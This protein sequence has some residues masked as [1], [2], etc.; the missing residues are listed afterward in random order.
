VPTRKALVVGAGIGGLAAAVALRRAGWEVR[1]FERATSPRELGFALLLAPNAMYALGELGLADTIRRGGFIATSGEMRRPDGSVL[2]RFDTASLRPLLEEDAVCILRP[3]LHGALLETVGLS[4]I[5]LEAPAIRFDLRP[6]GVQVRLADGRTDD[7]Q[8]LVG[9]D[10]VASVIR[11]QLHPDEPP[12]RSSGLLAVRGVARDAVP[13]LEGSS[14]AQYFGRGFEAGVARAGEREVYWYLSI[15][16]RHFPESRDV[17]AIAERCAAGFHEPFRAI[18]RETAPEDLRLDELFE[19]DP[20]SPWGHGVVTLLGDAAHPMLPHAGQGAAQ[21]LEDAVVLGSAL[22]DAHD[23]PN[24][25]SALRRYEQLRIPRT[26]AVVALA[27]R[28]SRMGSI[29]NPFGCWV[30][31][32]IIRFIP[33]TV[34]L[35]SLVALGKP[36]R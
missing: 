22:R 27:R 15:Q 10:G 32:Q 5:E 31:D 9:A 11:R 35:K 25:G 6:D 30:R 34:I 4:S 16:A 13:H 7:G 36:P 12:P 24:I 2:R 29:D 21:A 19:R 23:A 3:V 33:E 20:I 18:V 8:L 26:R 28:N 17:V 1:V 14:G